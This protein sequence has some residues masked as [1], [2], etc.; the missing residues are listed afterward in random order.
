MPDGDESPLPQSG[1]IIA[2]KYRVERVL[3][4]GGMGV[5]FVA[6]HCDLEQRVALKMM[7]PSDDVDENARARFARE[8]KIAAKLRSEHVARVLDFGTTPLTDGGVPLPY[9]VMEYLEG[10]DLDLV[11]KNQGKLE[12]EQAV[13][14]LLHA[15]E[16]VAEAHARGIVH[17]DLKPAN[18]FLT[19][20][21]DGSPCVKVLDFGISKL[22]SAPQRASSLTATGTA[23]GTPY[24]MAPE[25]LESAKSADERSD[26]WALGVV[27]Y[28]LLT[29]A[30]PFRAE[31]VTEICA[32]VLLHDPD[33]LSLR[34]ESIPASL[35]E[36]VMRCLCKKPDERWDS[37]AEFALALTEFAPSRAAMYGER[38]AG[39]AGVPSR[40]A[41]EHSLAVGA[42][43]AQ[44]GRSITGAVWDRPPEAGSKWSGLRIGLVGAAAIGLAVAGMSLIPSSPSSVSSGDAASQV[45]TTRQAAGPEV[46]ATEATATVAARTDAAANAAS[47]TTAAA[48]TASASAAVATVPTVPVPTVPVPTVPVPAAPPAARPP[49]RPTISR[50][51]TPPATQ[52]PA[53]CSTNPTT[54]D[55][56]GK[57]V[58]RP[59][60]RR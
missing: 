6:E 10:T 37:V 41:E 24:Y 18:L 30:V 20:R 33:P 19:T 49:A 9:L 22:T 55:A 32:Q 59:E 34:R 4:Q 14:Y 3:G 57:E 5:V 13:E 21:A 54:L 39:V 43:V 60:C 26:I 28:E 56:T 31:S 16:A 51:A 40:R 1:D 12:I 35:E 7:L 25:Q 42:T 17:R 36:A 11:I 38:V 50:P 48:T 53:Y 15:C 8:A 23:L 46:S 44:G 52:R 2:H 45:T 58:I 47:A 29:S 27:A